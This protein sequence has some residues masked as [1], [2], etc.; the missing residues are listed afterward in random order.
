LFALIEV[1]QKQYALVRKSRALVFTFIET[2]V[3][4]DL[5]A[6]VT[7]F[8]NQDIRHLLVHNADCYIY[9]LAYMALEHT[10]EW[11]DEKDFTSLADI[12]RL[13][14][15]VDELM[16]VF[17]NKFE[18]GMDVPINNARSRND[19]LNATPLMIFTHVTTHEFHH[20]GQVM[21]MCRQLGYPPPETDVYRFFY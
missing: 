16:D 15:Q 8:Q 13:Y 7:A 17:L 4:N 5:T 20:K 9:W 2:A 10:V 1:L 12:L 19:K 14:T 21:S 11:L 3:C 18:N 6:P